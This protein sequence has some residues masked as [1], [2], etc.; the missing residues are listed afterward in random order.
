MLFWAASLSTTTHPFKKQP[1]IFKRM[2]WPPVCQFLK[3]LSLSLLT[4][5]ACLPNQVYQWQMWRASL[6]YDYKHKGYENKVKGG[7]FIT[8]VIYPRF[9]PGLWFG[10]WGSSVPLIALGA[11]LGVRRN[12]KVLE[13]VRRLEH[14]HVWRHREEAFTAIILQDPNTSSL[15]RRPW[16]RTGQLQG[17]PTCSRAQKVPLNAWFKALLLPSWNS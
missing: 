7:F 9:C 5:Q 2:I 16:E 4:H 10:G 1:C 17:H 8:A 11:A 15:P 6:S 3:L 12:S 13:S 14:A